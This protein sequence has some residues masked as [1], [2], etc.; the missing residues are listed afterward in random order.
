MN[1]IAIISGSDQKYLPFLKNLISSLKNTGALEIADLCILDVE[2]DSKYLEDLEKFIH[3]K[4]KTKFSLSLNFNEKENWF[5]LLTER[6][7]IQDYFPGY[8]KYI[9]LD[10]DTQV[11]NKDL[12]FNL[13]DAT[14][15]KDIA[16]APEQ[17]ET[18]VFK[19]KKFGIKRKFFSLYKIS[20]WSFKNYK[21]YFDLEL[22]ENLLFK[23][24]FNNGVFCIKSSSKI[25][26]LWK[27]EYQ[28]ALNKAKSSYGIKTDQLSLNKV[29]FENF[30]LVSILDSTN[31]WIIN[32]SEPM[33]INLQNKLFQ[34]PSFPRRKINLLHFT[35]M[36][37]DEDFKCR[38]YLDNIIY[39]K[40]SNLHE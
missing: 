39:K 4:K 27:K 37:F 6:P 25:W 28:S 40:I 29:L 5:K 23:P 7:F 30:D 10:A 17:N 12:I 22:A 9:W 16:I 19:N 11:L 2:N 13:D 24:L 14:N 33:I 21:K 15:L 18:Y 8:Q 36:K 32:K 3:I 38:D 34:T 26:D 35:N 20:G 1:K 31:N